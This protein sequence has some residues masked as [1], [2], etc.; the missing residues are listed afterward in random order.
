[1]KH[2]H[3]AVQTEQSSTATTPH[4]PLTIHWALIR[5]GP[6]NKWALFR[7]IMS[8]SLMVEQLL[9]EV[10]RESQAGPL[11]DELLSALHSVFGA[12]LLHALAILDVDGS[13][14]LYSCPSGR[15]LYQV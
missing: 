4:L 9:S 13:V 1:M 7:I 2:A 12:P 6:I 11:S 15:M 10:K 5:K 8:L 14:T 3:S